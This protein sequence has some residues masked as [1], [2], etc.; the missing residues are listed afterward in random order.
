MV[1]LFIEPFKVTTC[2]EKVIISLFMKVGFIFNAAFKHFGQKFCA[3][4]FTVIEHQTPT[5]VFIF[6]L[7]AHQKRANYNFATKNYNSK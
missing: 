7:E 2:G 4:L 3:F 6:E 1:A 5:I